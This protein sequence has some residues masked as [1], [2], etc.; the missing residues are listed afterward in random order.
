MLSTLKENELKDYINTSPDMI[1]ASFSKDSLIKSFVSAGMIDDRTK[2]YPDMHAII[3]SF[4][5]N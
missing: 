4:K 3:Y 2:T 5:I 1:A